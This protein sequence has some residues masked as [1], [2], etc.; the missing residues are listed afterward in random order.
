LFC[1][2][3]NLTSDKTKLHVESVWEQ[4]AEENTER[5]KKQEAGKLP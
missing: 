5:S 1:T 3:I 4:D 2:G